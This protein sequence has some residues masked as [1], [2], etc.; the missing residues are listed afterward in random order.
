M[1]FIEW[2]LQFGDEAVRAIEEPNVEVEI[3]VEEHSNK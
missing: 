3:S 2:E 1:E